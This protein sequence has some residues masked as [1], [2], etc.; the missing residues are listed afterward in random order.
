VVVLIES[1]G[2][3]T[4]SESEAVMGTAAL[5]VTR[6]VK[7]PEVAAVGTPEIVPF[8]ASVSPAGSDPLAIDQV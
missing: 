3:F 1:A 2:L 6:T 8:G 7:L 4:V 5:S